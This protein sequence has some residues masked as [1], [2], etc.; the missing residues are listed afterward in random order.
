MP[1]AL[2][3]RMPE[4]PRV[5]TPPLTLIA[6]VDVDS[7]AREFLREAGRL[8]RRLDAALTLVHV[9]SAHCAHADHAL[10]E[11]GALARELGVFA[12]T[13]RMEGDPGASIVELSRL[14]RPSVILV[15]ERNARGPVGERFGSI[16]GYVVTRASCPVMIFRDDSTA[17]LRGQG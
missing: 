12:Q 7:V 13:R 8:S 9:C 14:L 17:S 15:G 1:V 6:A 2:P 4:S 5:A 10:E 3:A 11:I 16:A